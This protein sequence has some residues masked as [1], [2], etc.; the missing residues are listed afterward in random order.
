MGFLCLGF[1]FVRSE[2]APFGFPFIGGHYLRD[3]MEEEVGIRR[4]NFSS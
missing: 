1:D 2:Q 3:G 4:R